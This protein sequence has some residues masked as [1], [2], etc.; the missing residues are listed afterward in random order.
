MHDTIDLDRTSLLAGSIKR[1]L[2]VI[3]D[4]KILSGVQELR[5]PVVL[6]V[7]STKG[8]EGKSTKAG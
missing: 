2:S 3:E 6:P 5:F 7:V 1:S 4:N 8:G